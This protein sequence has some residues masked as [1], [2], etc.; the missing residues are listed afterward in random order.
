[1]R[2]GKDHPRIIEFRRLYRKL[3]D[4][5]DD[6]PSALKANASDDEGLKKLCI[7]LHFAQFFIQTDEREHRSSFANRLM[8]NSSPI[9]E[10]TKIAG[11]QFC[12][13]SLGTKSAPASICPRSPTPRQR[14]HLHAFGRQPTR[15]QKK[16]FWGLM[17]RSNKQSAASSLAISQMGIQ[18][19]L[20][21]RFENFDDFR[22]K[23]V[24]ISL[25]FCDADNSFA[26]C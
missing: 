8:L 14:I 17:L 24:L 18:N 1:M 15:V 23:S 25:A 26:W 3:R 4:W 20:S 21:V 2:A 9:G 7:D 19:Q 12:Q 22:G 11:T 16:R 10:I 6:D 13:T 5:A